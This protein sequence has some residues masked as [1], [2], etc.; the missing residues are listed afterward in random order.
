MSADGESM[1]PTLGSVE[2]E[3]DDEHHQ[4][5]HQE[6]AS[7]IAAVAALSTA[8][9]S[10]SSTA[11]DR[12]SPATKAADVVRIPLL[13]VDEVQEQDGDR[14]SSEH[15]NDALDAEI[16]RFLAH[17]DAERERDGR[18]LLEQ[19]WPEFATNFFSRVTF[20]WLNPLL[21]TGYEHPLRHEELWNLDPYDS[22]RSCART[23]HTQWSS[24]RSHSLLRHLYSCTRW[25]IVRSG[26]LK[27]CYDLLQFTGPVILGLLIGYV[28][29]G[30]L[31]C[32]LACVVLIAAIHWRWNRSYLNDPSIPWWVGLQYVVVLHVIS[33][34][35]TLLVQHYFHDV[36]RLGSHVRATG[37][38]GVH[39]LC[40]LCSVCR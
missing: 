29:A 20:W 12:D 19:P 16:E 30:L 11:S 6:D 4:Q 18:D 13:A 28:C 10:S 22:A 5:H 2:D 7:A 34:T 25:Q 15:D 17:T 35:R 39:V 40:T 36:S 21:S 27:V 31:A 38:F 3:E 26:L 9:S 32:L 8:S 33:S 1:P 37:T 23:F 14:A 24:Q